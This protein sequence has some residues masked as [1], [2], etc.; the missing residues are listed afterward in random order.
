[1]DTI[2]TAIRNFVARAIRTD[3]LSDTD[4]IFARGHVTSLFA[5]QLVMF[6]EHE[7]GI[8]VENDDLD[9]ANFSTIAGLANLVT[10]KRTVGLPESVLEGRP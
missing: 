3:L 10:R 2:R 6:V 5:M 4:D 1:M 8:T 7:F 9:I